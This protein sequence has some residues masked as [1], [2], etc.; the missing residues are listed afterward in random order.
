MNIMNIKEI[1][2]IKMINI[3]S[4]YYFFSKKLPWNQ[5]FLF[6]M[7]LNPCTWLHSTCMHWPKLMH[8][9]EFRVKEGNNLL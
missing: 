1:K 2:M 3:D 7:L 4:E 6:L 5:K 9:Q 8:D